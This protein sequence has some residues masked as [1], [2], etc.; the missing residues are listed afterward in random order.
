M[1]PAVDEEGKIIIKD[2]NTIFMAP[3]GN[4]GLYKALKDNNILK[5]L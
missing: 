3:N 1:L 5:L 4:G 2:K